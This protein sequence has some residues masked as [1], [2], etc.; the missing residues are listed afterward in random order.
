LNPLIYQRDSIRK[1][2]LIGS[3]GLSIGQAGE[4][5]YSGSQAIKALKEEDIEVIVINPNIATVQTSKNLGKA[6]PDKVYFLP[7]RWETV[8]LLPSLLTLSRANVIEEIIA[9]ERPDGVLVSMGGQTALNVGIELW[10]AGVFEKYNCRVLGTSIETII[11]TEDRELFSKKLAEI[12]ERLALS[13]RFDPFPASAPAI[14]RMCWVGSNGDWPPSN[15]PSRLGDESQ[16]AIRWS[17]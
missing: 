5:D 13:Y 17:Q 12:D 16:F 11:A 3:G 4:F 10:R 1:V 6:S 8:P 7:I 14:P 2:L 9:K 15:S